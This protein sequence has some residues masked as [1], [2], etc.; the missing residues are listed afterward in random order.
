MA[1]APSPDHGPAQ[2]AGLFLRSQAKETQTFH[3][4]SDPKALR[5]LHADQVAL[6]HHLL[7]ALGP[8]SE[9]VGQGRAVQPAVGPE[10]AR[11]SKLTTPGQ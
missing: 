7:G 10:E 6:P 2:P 1:A 3:F 9:T 11:V 5:F 8:A 4:I